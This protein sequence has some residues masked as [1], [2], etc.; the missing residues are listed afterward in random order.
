MW[1]GTA[2]GTGLVLLAVG[3]VP[4]KRNAL[5]PHGRNR[6]SPFTA[7]RGLTCITTSGL[8]RVVV[9]RRRA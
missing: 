8:S 2:I 9:R 1:R 7:T 4:A 3:V 6:S 5:R